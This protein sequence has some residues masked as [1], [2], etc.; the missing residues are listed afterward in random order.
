MKLDCV[1]TAVNENKLYLDMLP[2]F[3]K[4]WNKLYPTVDIKIV[5]I[6]DKIPFEY[7]HY[8][9]NIILFKPINNVS[10]NFISQYIRLLYPALLNYK[11]GVMITDIDNFPMNRTFFTENI[12]EIS[13]DKWINLRDWKT[14]N[15][16]SM[17]WQVATPKIWNQV[18]KINNLND[19][20]NRLIE[21]FESINYE[22]G[23]AKSGWCTDQEHLFKYVKEWN[24]KTNNYIFLK[25]IDTNYYRL[26]I[27]YISY[28]KKIDVTKIEKG[29]FSD[30]HCP[31]SFN[32]NIIQEI[33]NRL[34]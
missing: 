23:H 33:Y 34:I 19:I 30:F 26:D 5:L 3:I 17:C 28:Y 24:D 9:K 8:Q 20:N 12:K 18:F 2:F 27:D 7:Q 10:T 29:I 14:H 32:N 21:V 1:L 4:F 16:I 13:K 25:D 11:N 22:D 31:K 15:E 6:A